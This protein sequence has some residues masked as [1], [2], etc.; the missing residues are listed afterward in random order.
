[1]RL[2]VAGLL[3]CVITLAPIAVQA[4]AANQAA[5]TQLLL[6]K[7]HSFEVRGRMDLAA[8][9]WQQI[10]LADPN[11]TEALGGLARAAKLNGN[12]ALSNT[13]LDR[14]KA[15]NPNDP[16]IARVDS[17]LTQQ[18]Q[19]QQ[20]QQAG[21]LAQAGQYAQAMDIYRQVFGGDPPPGDWALA[22]Y[23]TEAATEDGR[24]HAIAGLQELVAKYPQ[25]SRYQ[26]TLGRILTYNPKTRSQGQ[27][28]LAKHPAN[29]EAADAL[30]QSLLWDSQNPAS[31]AEIRAYL[32][33]HNDPQLAKALKESQAE[34][35]K[36]SRPTGRA[37]T[38]EEQ[39]EQTAARQRTATEAAAYSALNAKHLP[40]AEERFKAILAN[41]PE[42]GPALAGMGYIRMN[43]QNFGGA[44][45]FLTQ[46]KQNGSKDPGLDKAIET[47]RFYYT[48]S[49]GAVALNEN[50]LTTAE[51]QYREALRQRPGSPEALLGLGGTLL[52]A[53]QPEAATPIYAQYVK[54]K[55]SDPAA[56][57]GLFMAQYQAGHPQAALE[58]EKRIPATVHAQLMKDPDFLRTLASAYSAVGRDA[59]AQRVLKG[60]LDLPFPADGK[61]LKAETQLQYAGLLQQSN[62]LDQAAGLYRQVLSDDPANVG[63]WQGLVRVEH[64]MNQDAAAVATMESMPPATYDEALKDPGFLSTLAAV[65]EQQNQ[66]DVAQGFLEK[67]VTMDT[68]A[69]QQPPVPLQLQLAAIYLK[70][71]N[72]QQAYGIYRQVLINNPDRTDAWKGLLAA[73]HSTGHDREAVAQVQ[74]IPL[75]TRKTLE[76]DPDYLQTMAGVYNSVGEPQQAAILLNRVTQHYAAAHEA[77]PADIQIQDAWLLFNSNNDAG[78]YPALMQLGGRAD[79][80]D[81]QRR[82]VQTIWANWAVRRANQTAAAENYK[83]SLAILNAAA[84]AFPD[85]PGVF[86]ALAGGYMRAGNPKQAELIFKAQD[87]T[88]A[89][90]GDYK[91]AVAAALANNDTKQAEIWLRY[92]LNL[93]PHDSQMLTQAAKFEQAAGNQGRAADYYR[94]SLAAMPPDD[95]GSDLAA[96]LSRPVP[97]GEIR[98]PNAHQSQDLASLLQPGA[99]NGNLSLP[100]PPPYLPSYQNQYGTPPVVLNNQYGYTEQPVVPSYMSNPGYVNPNANGYAY[101]NG[102]QAAPRSSGRLGDY[103]PQS[104]N[105]GGG[106]VPGQSEGGTTAQYAEISPPERV[107]NYNPQI[108]NDLNSP[109]TQQ[110]DLSYQAYQQA[111]VARLTADAQNAPLPAMQ[112][113]VAAPETAPVQAEVYKPYVPYT[114]IATDAM[115]STSGATYVAGARTVS[116]LPAMQSPSATQSGQQTAEQ[117][118]VLPAI[119]YVP[120]QA[121][122]SNTARHSNHADIAAYQAEGARAQQSVPG[123]HP[124]NSM[125]GQSNPPPDTYET[126]QYT[127]GV[128]VTGNSYQQVPQPGTAGAQDPNK[129]RSTTQVQVVGGTGDSN[130]QQYPQPRSGRTTVRRAAP[131]PVAP[132]PQQAPLNYPPAPYQLGY[133]PYPQIG[134]PYPLGTP[135]TDPQLMQHN[136]PPLRG[137]YNPNQDYQLSQQ[138]SERDQAELDLAQLEAS[139]S[140]WLGGTGVAR[141]RSGTPGLDRLTDFEVPFEASVVLSKTVRLSV[142]PRA[143][144]LN[145]GVPNGSAYP[146]PASINTVPI[147]GTA[148]LNAQGADIQQPADGVGGEA[149]LVTQNFG[150]AVGYS[151][152]EFLVRNILGHFRWKPGGG[153]FT[154]FVDRDNVKDTIL[155]YA[156][157]RDPNGAT[158]FNSGPIWG[159]VVQTGGGIRFDKGNEKNGLYILMEGADLSGYHVLENRKYDGTMGAYWRVKVWPEYGSLNIGMTFFGE[160]YSYNELGMTYGLGGYFSPEV[161]FLGAIPITYT[162]HYGTNWHYIIAGAVGIQAFEQASQIYFPLDQADQTRYM[163]GCSQALII[164][165]NCAET[166]LSTNIG[167]NYN[168]DAEGSYRIAD[169][170]YIGGFLSGNNTSNYNTVSGGF[171]VRYLFKPQFPTADYPTG[172]FP[173]DGFRNLRVP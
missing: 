165:Q 168:I 41:D 127:G 48:L 144:F 50:D 89:S 110:G 83:R 101:P 5:T 160:H 130:G 145:A 32:S 16:N 143:V 158:L 108:H 56:W 170:W 60:A 125:E 116:Q 123:S 57:R 88:A 59:D 107:L 42:N 126:T 9:T 15:I 111:Q 99:D 65:Y 94:A 47:S 128:D 77:P 119:H 61:G 172:L 142:I 49:E 173:H 40:E 4:Q 105:D 76:S 150:L 38:P 17:M 26:I 134:Q 54:L 68:T 91:S 43:Q 10:L 169:H 149:Q 39:A 82:T 36:N 66:L 137:S 28:L 139:Y 148:Y 20:L 124:V 14:L 63:A 132:A 86:K 51:Q 19:V 138:L 166:P 167:P 102:A 21:K 1:M 103:V 87:M 3:A 70:R 13:Y 96:E 163:S 84:R 25:D 58:T 34:A 72:A 141:Y 11:N 131:V 90:P 161:Y 80:T 120:N 12:A 44:I 75:A 6:D 114:P 67:A 122:T 81:E 35:A 159:G 129:Q 29:P 140:G 45:S 79:L 121:S 30:R 55:P 78:L 95:P 62:R 74:Q 18:N 115:L 118:D 31:G 8:Q 104:L 164:A 71:G 157:L 46:A 64:A 152:Y 146:N 97:P 112:Q 73:L 33:K 109:S 100:Q 162:G 69:G 27:A 37:L 2:A 153:P 53:Q 85:N 151:P 171:F 155:S 133:Q 98:L 147:L 135:P 106:G 117:T 22:Y 136:I 52:K 156:G 24:P 7:A 23:E 113:T 154:L 92:G 93:Y